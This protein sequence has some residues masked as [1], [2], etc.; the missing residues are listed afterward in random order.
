M[1][2]LGAGLA[3]LGVA[4]A[5]VFGTLALEVATTMRELADDDFRFQSAPDRQRSLWDD[6][7]FL[8]GSVGVKALGLEDDLAYRQGAAVFVMAAPGKGPNVG[9]QVEAA[10]GQASLLLT[11]TSEAE[12]DARRRSQLLNFLG[13]LPLARELE[14]AT[15]RSQVLRA[16]A[17][18][19]ATAVEVDP[20][21]A[22]AK[23][24][25]E[26]VLRDAQTSGLPP[27]AP[28]GEADRG[29]RSSPGGAVG[30]GY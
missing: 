1:R 10:R 2:Y 25:L 17:G 6:L 5:V 16:A 4:L 27:N 29:Q 11:R 7:G 23:W 24:N 9:P 8:P 3:A 30:G 28:S 18:T 12:T 20:T 13:L 14:D 26:A 22:D 19:F 21:N 15:E